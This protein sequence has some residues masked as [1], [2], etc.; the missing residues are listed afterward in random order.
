[1]NTP[2]S[3]FGLF[4]VRTPWALLLLL[5]LPLWWWY[6]SRRP[7]PAITFSRADVLTR[8]RRGSANTKTLFVLRNLVLIAAVIALARP[9]ARGRVESVTTSGINIVL[10]IDLSSSML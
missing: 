1:M 2:L 5:A 9:Q 6:R 3:V 4:E 8:I 7:Q 10:A